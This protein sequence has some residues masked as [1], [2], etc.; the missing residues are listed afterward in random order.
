MP[1]IV[2]LSVEADDSQ[3]RATLAK[4]EALV[5]Q[6]AVKMQAGLQPLVLG[7]AAVGQSAGAAS[8]AVGLLGATASAT[9]ST[10]LASAAQIGG[11][12]AAFGGLATAALAGAAGIKAMTVA[13]LVFIATPIGAVVAA[14]GVVMLA[15]SAIFY[16][17]R[18]EQEAA[19]AVLEKQREKLKQVTEERKKEAKALRQRIAIAEGADPLSFSTRNTELKFQV[20]AAE[21]AKK[22]RDTQKATAAATE[23]RVQ[24]LGRQLQVMRGQATEASFIKDDEER[25]LTIARAQLAIDQQRQQAA[26]AERKAK[27]SAFAARIG[28]QTASEASKLVAEESKI[29]TFK[30][31]G[32]TLLRDEVALRL[33]LGLIDRKRAEALLAQF[34]IAKAIAEQAK[35]ARFGEGRQIR[36]SLTALGG[37]GAKKTEVKDVAVVKAIEKQTRT[38]TRGQV[39]MTN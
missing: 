27:E 13:S 15:L 33:K 2:R 5:R 20:R 3:L 18:R 12:G 4:D 17:N 31:R 36:L 23:E 6:S 22:L 1:E 19:N 29:L 24:A 35:E 14:L 39:A 26:E 10:A 11:M 32:N 37:P 21:E 28:P 16:K 7:Q 30:M 8:A 9:G 38:L 34:G 25:R